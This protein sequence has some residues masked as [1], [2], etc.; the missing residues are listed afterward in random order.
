MSFR[1]EQFHLVDWLD[2]NLSGTRYNLASSGM[3][4]PSLEEFEIETNPDLLSGLRGQRLEDSLGQAYGVHSSEVLVCAGGTLAIYLAIASL[5][6][7]GDQVLIPMPNYPPEY[8]VPR[9]LGAKLEEVKIRYESGF[10]LD[11]DSFI[12]AISKN[13]RMVVLTN[14]NNPTGLKIT[15]GELEKIAEAAERSRAL[16]FV[17]ET[18]REFAED[19]APVARSLGDHVI[20]AGSMTKF[21]G[22]G[23]PKIGW[24]FAGKQVM[25]KIR[26]LNQWVSVEESRLSCMIGIQAMEKKKLLDL[27]TH[28]LTRENLALGREF[29]KGNSEFL[30][31][32]E[33]DGAPF[34]FPKIKLPLTSR[35]FC[36]K[37]VEKYSIL[38][39]PGDLFEYPG[40]FRLCLTRLPEKTRAGLSAFSSA[41]SEISVAS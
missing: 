3:E 24:L 6:K 19:P 26:S 12:R 29:M 9:I 7:A 28:R 25:E 5:V 33:P 20:S 11:V 4:A 27:R 38:V 34:G 17:D 35:D 10:R 16:V 18:F 14:S 30:E 39:S 36:S 2:S 31:W 23:D 40:H 15:R 22:L 41:L 8:N 13:T 1:H 21:F 32:I 37:L